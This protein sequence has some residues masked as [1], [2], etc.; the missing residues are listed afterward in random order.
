[1]TQRSVTNSEEKCFGVRKKAR[2]IIRQESKS[3][4]RGI[5]W[6]G[7]DVVETRDREKEAEDR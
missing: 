2:Q 1:M 6:N 4:C 5:F 3:P 7:D